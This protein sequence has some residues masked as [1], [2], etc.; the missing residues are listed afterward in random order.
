MGASKEKWPLKKI[1]SKGDRWIHHG[2]WDSEVVP[3]A[4]A[5]HKILEE[6]K[7]IKKTTKISTCKIPNEFGVLQLL[8]QSPEVLIRYQHLQSHEAG[9]GRKCQ[10]PLP[11]GGQGE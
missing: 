10:R 4:S 7:K 3:G 8:A 5:A 6:I 9:V 2:N 11:G 1:S